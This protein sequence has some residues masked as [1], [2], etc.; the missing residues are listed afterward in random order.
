MKLPASIRIVEVAPRD[1]FQ[2]IKPWIETDDKIKVVTSLLKSGVDFIEAT[3]FVSPK[4]IAQMKDAAEIASA[5]MEASV[6]DKV[7]ALAPN[8]RGVEN[9]LASGIKNIAL[10]ISASEAHNQNNVRRTPAQ[11]LEE[12]EEIRERFPEVHIKLDVATAFGCP[13]TGEVPNTDITFLIDRAVELAIFDVVLCDTVGVGNPR[14]INTL[15]GLLTDRYSGRPMDWGLHFHNTRGL[16]AA[17]TLSALEMGLDRF[18][19]AAGGLGGCPFAPGASGNMATEDLVFMMQE[20]G[21]KTNVDLSALVAC[22]EF[23]NEKVGLT[24]DRKIG[25]LT[26]KKI[27]ANY[28]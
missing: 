7:Y 18:E 28:R 27:T 13:F 23:M 1:G 8:A 9:A 22:S 14:Q 4:A 16:A 15:L 5:V 26:V 19:T 25:R 11:S 17:N 20:M 10:V 3:S 12:L 2:S 21:I 6:Q 24:L